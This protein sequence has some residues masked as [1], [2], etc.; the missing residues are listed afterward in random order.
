MHG[1]RS[2]VKCT[3]LFRH[4]RVRPLLALLGRRIKGLLYSTT[5]AATAAD[6]VVIVV[7]CS[8]PGRHQL[9]SD[10]HCCCSCSSDRRAGALLVGDIGLVAMVAAAADAVVIVHGCSPRAEHRFGSDGCCRC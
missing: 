3:D 5:T 10:G 2:T 9:G 1:P 4:C 6:A 7:R 8:P